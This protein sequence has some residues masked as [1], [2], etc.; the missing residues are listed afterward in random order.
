MSDE[1]VEIVR[2]IYDWIPGPPE[3]VRK[4]FDP[5]YEMDL[6]DFQMDIGVVR[7]FDAVD[8][9][10][11]QYY[12]AFETF[13]IE[14]EELIDADEDHVVASVHDG[15]RMR[16][17]DSEVRTHR[18]HV[19]TFRDGKVVRFSGHYDRNRALEAAGLQE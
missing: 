10:I 16:G 6:T 4:F 3:P 9:A 2:R 17:S 14:I 7:G 12:E 8:R 1:N 19:W 15:G 18:F 13:H 11:R 5:D